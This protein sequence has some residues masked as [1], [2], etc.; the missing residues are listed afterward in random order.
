MERPSVLFVA[1]PAVAPERQALLVNLL[2][3]RSGLSFY[4]MPLVGLVVI[5]LGLVA[6]LG[7][8]RIRRVGL[9]AALIVCYMAGWCWFL[10]T[11]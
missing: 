7:L 4:L 8:A 10:L 1:R 6:A 11:I 3:G 2:S 9:A 5:T